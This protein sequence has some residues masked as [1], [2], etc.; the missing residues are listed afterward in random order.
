MNKIFSRI[1]HEKS[2]Y[3][4]NVLPSMPQLNAKI[5]RLDA[6]NDATTDDGDDADADVDAKPVK[7]DDG[8][9]TFRLHDG[10]TAKFDISLT[11]ISNR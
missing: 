9:D 11:N 10:E 5:R 2:E 7:A 1:K 3:L 6:I 8:E 4:V